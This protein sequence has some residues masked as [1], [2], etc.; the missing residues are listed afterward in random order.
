MEEYLK[1][2]YRRIADQKDEVGDTKS[3]DY[4][5]GQRDRKMA[6]PGVITD[7]IKK[8]ET[9]DHGMTD[10]DICFDPKSQGHQSNVS[11]KLG[12]TCL[13]VWLRKHCR[14][15]ARKPTNNPNPISWISPLL[16]STNDNRVVHGEPI[17]RLLISYA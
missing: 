7:N 12:E 5:K 11:A 3:R 9:P 16:S 4:K 10:E 2:G 15:F 13:T 8:D 1:R 17:F 14:H 6:E